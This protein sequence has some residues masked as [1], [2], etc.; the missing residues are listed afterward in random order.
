MLFEQN[1]IGEVERVVYS[2]EGVYMVHVRIDK[3]FAAAATEDTDFIIVPDPE[4][5]G[6]NAV[7]LVVRKTGGLLLTQGAQVEGK[8]DNPTIVEQ[9]EEQ[10]GKS[11]E[12]LKK[13][14]KGFSKTFKKFPESREFRKLEKELQE[15]S[16]E[17][18]RAGKALRKKM[19]EEVLPR[20]EEEVERLKEQLRKLGREKEVRPLE[21]EL[22]KL[23]EI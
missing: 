22:E 13:Y 16:Q 17:M 2:Q 23:R 5:E 11:L 1:H 12:M 21:T 15:L 7:E 9:L 14:F 4:R 10:I 6:K 18:E 8:A 19:Q 20:I 3:N